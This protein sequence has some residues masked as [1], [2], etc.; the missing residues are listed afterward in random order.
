MWE[1]FNGQAMKARTLL[2]GTNHSCVVNLQADILTVPSRPATLSF[3]LVAWIA[4]KST[5]SHFHLQY[6]IH[7]HFGILLD[8]Q[9][10]IHVE[11][12]NHL[13]LIHVDLSIGCPTSA[14]AQ[15]AIRE[16]A[17]HA[18]GVSKARQLSE[19]WLQ[20]KPDKL[21]RALSLSPFSRK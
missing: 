6:R 18:R 14:V 15:R 21:F 17:L 16:A 20:S 2:K 19:G 7:L 11:M 8:I 12:Q 9:P 3:D 5:T 13:I 10:E 1:A 4:S